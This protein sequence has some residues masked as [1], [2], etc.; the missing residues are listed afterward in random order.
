MKKIQLFFVIFIIIVMISSVI[1]FVYTR[2]SNT[3]QNTNSFNYN[4]ANFNPQQN[5]GYSVNVNGNNFIFDYLPNELNNIELPDFNLEANK[6]YLIFNA[7]EYD[8]NL[9]YSLNKLGYTLKLLG[10]M[11]NTACINEQNCD[12]N[13]PIKDCSNY[14]FY[15]KKSNVNK[16][17]LQDKCIILEGDNLGLSK[18]VDR[19][20]LKL[21]GIK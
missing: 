1:G 21:V 19:I 17:Y 4:G 8:N 14:A 7:T 11:V 20:N 12:S 3:N 2:P 5:G 18:L 16:V 10:I 13:L 15:L 6:Y 9:A